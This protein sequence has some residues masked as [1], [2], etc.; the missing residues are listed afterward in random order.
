MNNNEKK[1][2]E[3]QLIPKCENYIQYE[4]EMLNKLPRQEKFNIGNEY[5]IVMYQ[6]LEEIHYIQKVEVGKWLYH[7]NKI[8]ALLNI[9][10]SFLR[11]MYKNR[12]I[13][14]KKFNVSIKHI[15][16]IGRIVGGLI[17]Y[18]GQNTKKFL[19]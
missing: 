18:Y 6:T 16:E 3:L 7:L 13:D 9:Q 8:D 4:I 1:E 14:C 5:K 17:K 15:T 11:I 10:R 19:P 12:Y 2:K